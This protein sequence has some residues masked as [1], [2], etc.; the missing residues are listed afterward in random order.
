MDFITGVSDV[1][2]E[3]S[4]FGSDPGVD[5]IPKTNR[6]W[7]TMR[8]NSRFGDDTPTARIDHGR[9]VGYFLVSLTRAKAR[10]FPSVTLS[11]DQSQSSAFLL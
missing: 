3:L 8:A 9:L 11:I 1:S 4:L 10:I 7:L 2:S 6:R 5:S